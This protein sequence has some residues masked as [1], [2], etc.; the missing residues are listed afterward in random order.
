MAFQDGFGYGQTQTGRILVALELLVYFILWGLGF[1][2][3][4]GWLF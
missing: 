4:T 2:L 1:A 3:F